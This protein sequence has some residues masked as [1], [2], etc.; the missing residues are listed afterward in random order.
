MRLISGMMNIEDYNAVIENNVN[1][2][3]TLNN[4]KREF[5]KKFY[6]DPDDV[7]EQ[8]KVNGVEIIISTDGFCSIGKIIQFSDENDIISNYEYIR[9]DKFLRWPKYALSINQQR[10]YKSK[11]DDR[12][13]LLLLDIRKFYEIIENTE[14]DGTVV[15]T[16][17][18]VK[19]IKESCELSYAFLNLHTLI[20]LKN[21]GTFDKFIEGNNLQR[22]CSGKSV[23]N[24]Y[25]INK[26]STSN[27][28]DQ[29]YFDELLK[30]AKKN[31]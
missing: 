19:Q 20:W 23:D 8:K 31:D 24:H 30:N 5:D 18:Q 13:D 21:F 7:I 6:R 10:G 12:I 14:I 1:Y 28:F 11:F 25:I 9:K 2:L 3:R 4:I 17:E 22:F 29:T 27:Y 16:Y 15:I 26:W